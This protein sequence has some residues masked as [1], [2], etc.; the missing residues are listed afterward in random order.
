MTTTNHV[1]ELKRLRQADQDLRFLIK[2]LPGLNT[3]EEL[4]RIAYLIDDLS[5]EDAEFLRR[6]TV[7]LDEMRARFYGARKGYKRDPELV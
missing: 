1:A 5:G 2:R 3:I 7:R 6:L 4:E